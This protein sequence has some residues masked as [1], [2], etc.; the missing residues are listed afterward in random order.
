MVPGQSARSISSPYKAPIS[1][2]LIPAGAA[3]SSSTAEP[4][5]Q[6][7]IALDDQLAPHEGHLNYRWSQYQ[8]TLN[9]IL[10]YEGSL[11]NFA[12]GHEKFGII[13]ENGRTTYREWAPGA[14]SAQLIGDFNGWA[15]TW[16]QKD[17][18]GV[19]SVELPDDPSGAPAIPHGSRVKIRLQH[20]GGWWVDRL[21]AWIKWATV[22]EGV[23]GAK[24][25]GIHWDPPAN[26]KYQFKHKRPQKAESLRIYEAHVGMSS[27]SEGVAS[28]TYFKGKFKDE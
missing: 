26:E 23:M 25:D 15:G 5:P 24:F 21:P 10:E 4:G 1:R 20:P 16:M 22:P 17:D 8:R 13:H 3:G 19:W 11:E 12:L 28:Y 27:E 18:F 6:A 14:E 2:P 7:I 9:N